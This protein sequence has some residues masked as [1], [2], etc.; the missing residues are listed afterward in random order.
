MLSGKSTNHL[1]TIIILN[2]NSSS[3][4]SSKA[5][6]ITSSS[7]ETGY[8][9]WNIISYHSNKGKA[10]VNLINPII[11]EKY[12]IYFKFYNS[13]WY[14]D[15]NGCSIKVSTYKG[16]ATAFLLIGSTHH[17]PLCNAIYHQTNSTT[18]W[19]NLQEILSIF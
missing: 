15:S 3:T 13:I 9:I 19:N 11:T 6:W 12:I 16:K 14:C 18:S 10:L 8:T 17:I 5:Q 2:F 7:L 4:S 1:L